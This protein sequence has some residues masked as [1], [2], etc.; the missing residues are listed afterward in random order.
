[1]VATLIKP[2]PT[3]LDNPVLDL[4][5]ITPAEVSLGL[6]AKGR[7]G[8]RALENDADRP[9]ALGVA[10]RDV[11]ALQS[12]RVSHS[13]RPTLLARRA[14]GADWDPLL[15]HYSAFALRTAHAVL[16][17]AEATR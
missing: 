17:L 4:E 11:G 14:T 9:N 5:N 7:G 1:M 3:F 13:I 12:G 15:F 8:D 16:A 2:P 10:P 6:V